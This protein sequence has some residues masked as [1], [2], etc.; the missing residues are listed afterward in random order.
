MNRKPDWEKALWAYINEAS[1]KSF[2]Y[3]KHDCV[4]FAAG[5]FEAMYGVDPLSDLENYKSARR[6][7]QLIKKKGDGSLWLAADALLAE[8]GMQREPTMFAN[9]GDI[10]GSYNHEGMEMMGIMEDAGTCTFAAPTGVYRKHLGDVEVRW[11]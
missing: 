3:G 8:Y 9:K 6:A 1:A 7:Y 2:V 11:A 5:A 4:Q 10:V